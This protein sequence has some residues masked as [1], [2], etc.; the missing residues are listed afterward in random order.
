MSDRANILRLARKLARAS[1]R[2][3]NAHLKNPSQELDLARE[4]E[5]LNLRTIPPALWNELDA[6]LDHNPS[7][8]LALARVLYAIANRTHNTRLRAT[9]DL[10]LIRA[11]NV[12]CEFKQ[13]LAICPAAA[14]RFEKSDDTENVAR[15]WLEA[16]W[17]HTFLGDLNTARA[18]L[19]QV[20]DLLDCENQL[21]KQWIHARLLRE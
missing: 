10:A 13:T 17:T 1:A 21:H 8:G 7:F 18:L 20:G 11:L 16:A 19:V 2:R 14:R 12:C 3:H 4:I 15:V 5:T 6:L 9:A